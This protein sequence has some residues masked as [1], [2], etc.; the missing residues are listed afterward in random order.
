MFLSR[1][2]TSAQ[3]G[4]VLQVKPS[5]SHYTQ[6]QRDKALVSPFRHPDSKIPLHKGGIA[7]RRVSGKNSQGNLILANKDIK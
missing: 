4:K 2:D 1:V 7:E 3:G 6:T 5:L